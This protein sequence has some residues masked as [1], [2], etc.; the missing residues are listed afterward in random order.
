[1]AAARVAVGRFFDLSEFHC[2]G[3][4]PPESVQ[5]AIRELCLRVLDPLRVAVGR[6][7]RITSGWRSST[8]NQAVG[9]SRTS[10]HLTGEAADIKADGLAAADLLR[11]IRA[12]GILVDQAIGYD[13]ERGGHVHVAFATKRRNR[14]EYLWAPVA[15]GYRTWKP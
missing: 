3:E 12:A 2:R 10:M 11:A 9:G 6:P 13:P 5:P 15:G 7:I 1:M 14:G 4:L 8:V